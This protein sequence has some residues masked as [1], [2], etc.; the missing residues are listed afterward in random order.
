MTRYILM[1]LAGLLLATPAIADWV[2]C[3]NS[4]RSIAALSGTGR[5]ACHDPASADDDPSI[6]NTENCDQVDV[7]WYDDINGDGT[8]SA[9]SAALYTCP[10]SDNSTAGLDTEDSVDLVGPKILPARK[11]P[12]PASDI[13]EVLRFFQPYSGREAYATNR[14]LSPLPTRSA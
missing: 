8:A 9:G 14:G 2:G 11:I 10:S 12:L 1:V 3:T 7:F 6:L 5:T 13:G 4:S